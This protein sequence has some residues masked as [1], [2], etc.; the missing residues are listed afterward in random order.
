MNEHMRV[1]PDG[2]AYRAARAKLGDAGL[3][4]PLIGTYGK[5]SFQSLIE[6]WVGTEELTFMLADDPAPVA[7]C[8]HAMR[9]RTADIVRIAVDSEAESFI[10]WEDSST[11]NI[12]PDW[13]TQYTAPETAHWASMIHRQGKLLIH[14]ACGHLRALLTRMADTG[15]DVIESIS[16]PPTGNIELWE[17]RDLLPRN[18]VLIGG[19]EPT[20]FLHSTPG[21]L[22]THVSTL[23]GHMGTTGWILAN[24]DSCPPGV[25]LDKFRQ[26]SR[27]LGVLPES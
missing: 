20:T 1:L 19:I 22:D 5:S 2:D 23:L 25:T 8:L 4:V 15:I 27:M 12:T 18:I 26:V 21:E 10:F 17:A 9:E 16:P 11:Q 24:S 13:F 7:E 14:H 3:I 6:H